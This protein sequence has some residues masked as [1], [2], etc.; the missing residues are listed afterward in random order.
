MLV[1]CIHSPVA[2][3]MI[4]QDM[5]WGVCKIYTQPRLWWHDRVMVYKCP[6]MQVPMLTVS[7]LHV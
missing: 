7:L 4:E 1:D 6:V 2:C 5:F 3:K